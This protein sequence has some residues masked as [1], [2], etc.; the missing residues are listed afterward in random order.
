MER[1]KGSLDK[2][3]KILIIGGTGYIGYHLVRKCVSLGWSVSVFSIHNPKKDRKVKDVK[4]YQGNLVKKST[5]KKIDKNFDFIVN[6]GGY[7]DHKN[8]VKSLNTH[9]IGC[10]NLVEIFLKKKIKLFLQVGSGAE[11]GKIRSPHH[12]SSD[13]KPKSIY[14]TPKFLASK[15]LIQKFKKEGFPCC[16]VRLYQVYG[17]KQDSNRVIP[18]IVRSCLKNQPFPCSDGKQ[19]RDFLD[20]EQVVN[21]LIKVL[22]TKKVLGEIINIGSGEAISIKFLIK[23]ICQITKKGKPKFGMIKM[24]SDENKKVYP[25]INKAKKILKWY[26]K[27]NFYKKLISIINYEKKVLKYK[28]KSLI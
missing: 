12:E 25:N 1:K 21:V 28:F 11:Y 24:R 4:Y 3:T 9:Y 17:K 22:K 2:K 23:K 19:F 14:G 7:V 15:H 27:K 8:K 13:R 5:L 18:F 6:L 16:I 20:I 26:P 10:K